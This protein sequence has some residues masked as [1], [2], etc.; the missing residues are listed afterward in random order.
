M[1]GVRRG[2]SI[3]LT[4]IDGTEKV[5]INQF[6]LACSIAT[7]YSNRMYVRVLILISRGWASGPR[8]WKLWYL[9]V[10]RNYAT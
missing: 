3:I 5:E 8:K 6:T 10:Q 1:C 2:R 9:I 4:I 7:M